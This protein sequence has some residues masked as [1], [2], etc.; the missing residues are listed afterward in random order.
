[1]KVLS[2]RI[3]AEYGE[4]DLWYRP[5]KRGPWY[6]PFWKDLTCSRLDPDNAKQAI[7][8]DA[9]YPKYIQIHVEEAG[10][11]QTPDS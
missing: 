9:K 1:V 8:E 3:V 6:W 10:H 7:L 2:Y 11:G 5:Q 4:L